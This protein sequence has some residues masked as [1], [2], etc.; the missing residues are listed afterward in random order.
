MPRWG[1]L[2]LGLLALGLAML[3][4]P[5]QAGEDLN[6]GDWLGR[7]GVKLFAVECY[8]TWCKPCMEAMP[9]WAALKD[10]Y[11]KQGLLVVGVNTLDPQGGCR[12]IGWSPDDTVCDLEG[13]VADSFRLNGQLPA[14][15]LWSWQGN[16][17]VQKGHV[18]EVER[19][20]ERYL[21]D[22]PRVAM[23]AG[24]GIGPAVGGGDVT[25]AVGELIVTVQPKD[26][27]VEVS[28]PKG[29]KATGRGRW[30]SKALAAGGYTVKASAEGHESKT[31]TVKVEV[32]E[33][34]PLK[35][36]LEKLGVVEVTR[37]PAGAKVEIAG[38][39][40]F[41]ATAGL[42]VVLSDAPNGDYAIAVS[43]AGFE[44]ER[45]Q[46]TVR[47]GET[48]RVTVALKP[49]GSLVV[50]GTPVGAGVEIS[51]PGGLAVVKGL[52]V[53]VEGAA[54]GTYRV[55]VTR[56]RYVGIE[57]NAEVRAGQTASLAVKL[58]KESA[59]QSVVTGSGASGG[60]AGKAVGG[61]VRVEPGMFLMGSPESEVGQ[62][63]DEKQH[64][65][66]I[67]RPYWIKATEVTQGA[68]QSVMGEDP[69]FFSGCG[70]MCPVEMVSWRD[71]VEYCNKIIQ[72]RLE[73]R[74]NLPQ[75]RSDE[76]ACKAARLRPTEQARTAIADDLGSSRSCIA[77][78]MAC[79]IAMK[80]AAFLALSAE[81]TACQQRQN[82]STQPEPARKGRLAAQ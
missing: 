50:E 52:P 38:P 46:A 82:G 9:R 20:V 63:S 75:G 26:A 22:A 60:G 66:T 2:R 64:K 51:G 71:A 25:A 6:L 49:P 40:E 15:F 77:I 11:R 70:I 23:E 28:G 68:W 81:V 53:T 36:V 18:A 10:K 59:G 41:K 43:K 37:S 74:S 73:V 69:S 55:K 8:A 57:A 34:T 5:V 21:R 4:P 12:G 13:R 19:E 76:S 24:A 78:S 30:E 79:L 62:D 33:M 72:N 56:Q 7:S 44:V 65:V 35:V 61:W 67:T 42:P 29:F 16:L 14:A 31:A 48:T 80:T 45:Y 1:P 17:L 3:A 27:Y 39:E 54:R 32:D 58:V 47:L